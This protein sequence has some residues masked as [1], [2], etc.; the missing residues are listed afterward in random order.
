MPT[1]TIDRLAKIW[2]VCALM[3][4]FVLFFGILVQSSD[5]QL[6][7]EV[8]MPFFCM[9]ALFIQV[10][11]LIYTLVKYSAAMKEAKQL[12]GSA[13]SAPL[14]QQKTWFAKRSSPGLILLMVCLMYGWGAILEREALPLWH[15]AG[16]GMAGLLISV[17]AFA[18]YNVITCK[19]KHTE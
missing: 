19:P 12:A 18:G 1:P 14:I 17:I 16:L 3:T 6:I 10:C 5:D 7:F 4:V 2:V 13:L 15:L 8:E 11:A 9:F